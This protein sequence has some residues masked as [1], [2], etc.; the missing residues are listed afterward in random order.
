MSSKETSGAGMGKTFSPKRDLGQNVAGQIMFALWAR[1]RTWNWIV[2][3]T[4]VLALHKEETLI[5]SQ[6]QRWGETRAQK[7][8][9]R[10]YREK[11][12][13][14][15]R[16]AW[17]PW[18]PLCPSENDWSTQR[19]VR[20]RTAEARTQMFADWAVGSRCLMHPVYSPGNEPPIETIGSCHV[21]RKLNFQLVKR[22]SMVTSSG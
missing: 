18:A 12:M 10:E 2:I 3:Y 9:G 7:G 21:F 1:L 17:E 8:V 4:P 20:Q 13:R 5:K 6:M 22:S 11:E 15:G 19:L 14:S 16:L